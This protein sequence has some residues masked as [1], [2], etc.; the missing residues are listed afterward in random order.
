MIRK[1]YII[2]FLALP[3]G[4]ASQTTIALWEF[5][6]TDL[7]PF[8]TLSGDCEPNPM[9]PGTFGEENGAFVIR[10]IEGRICCPCGFMGGM[11]GCGF[12]DNIASSSLITIT[13]GAFCNITITADVRIE[14]GAQMECKLPDLPTISCDPDNDPGRDA[15]KIELLLDGQIILLGSYCGNTRRGDFT[16]SNIEAS[17]FQIIITGGTEADDEA[18]IIERIM[19]EGSDKSL[20]P[21]EIQTTKQ[22]YC[23]NEADVIRLVAIGGDAGSTYEWAFN[24]NPLNIPPTVNTYIAPPTL[25][26][27]GNYAV[28]ITETSG[29]T[30]DANVDITVTVCL[31]Q[32]ATFSMVPTRYCRDNDVLMLPDTSDEGVTGM[33]NVDQNLRLSDTVPFNQITFTP[34]PAFGIMPVDID[35]TIDTV[36]FMGNFPTDGVQICVYDELNQ[37]VNLVDLLQLEKPNIV[38]VRGFGRNFP[39][40]NDL[41]NLDV[42]TVNPGTYPFEFESIPAAE[43]KV[44]LI[45]LDI[46]VTRVGRGRDNNFTQCAMDMEPVDFDMLVSGPNI[47]SGR[48]IDIANTG[49]DLSQPDQVDV[50]ML[51]PGIYTF[52]YV[53]G[54]TPACMTINDTSTLTLEILPGSAI[55][56]GRFERTDLCEE[57]PFS[58]PVGGDIYDESNPSGT[59]VLFGE[60]ANGCDSTVIVNLVYQEPRFSFVPYFGCQGDGY[61]TIVNGTTYFEGNPFG[62]EMLTA[63]NGC[64]SIIT[65]D[66]IYNPLEEKQ[67]THDGCVGDGYSISINNIIYNEANPLGLDTIT[68]VNGCDTIVTIDLVFKPDTTG[69][70]TYFGN[71]GDVYNVTV[72][73]TL[74]DEFNP[75]GMEIFT[76]ANGCDS[77]VTID[78]VFVLGVIDSINTVHCSGDGYSVQAGNSTYDESNPSGVDSLKTTDNRD[79]VIITNLTFLLSGKNVIDLIKTSG[80]G[81][82]TTINSITYN[83]SNPTGFDTIILGAANGCDSLI[84]INIDYV[85]AAFTMIDSSFCIGDPFSITVGNSTYNQSNPAGRDTL[86]TV[87]GIDSIVSTNLVF[88]ESSASVFSDNRCSGDGFELTVG[89]ELFNEANPSGIVTLAGANKFGCDSLVQVLLIYTFDVLVDNDATICPDEEVS[90]GNSIYNADNRMGVDT[91]LG[92]GGCDTIITTTLTVDTINVDICTLPSCPNESNGTLKIYNLNPANTL[93]LSVNQDDFILEDSLIISNQESGSYVIEFVNSIGCMLSESIQIESL[94]NQ[95]PIINNTAFGLDSLQLGFSYGGAID[96]IEWTSNAGIICANCSSI[97]VDSRVANVYTLTIYD[98][99]GCTYLS[100]FEI[101]ENL[102]EEPIIFYMANAITDNGAPGNSRLFLQ[103]TDPNIISYDLAVYSRWGEIVYDLQNLSPND[104]STGWDGSVRGVIRQSNVFVYK[105]VI[106]KSDGTTQV[107]AGDVLLLK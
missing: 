60:A 28:T 58:F 20:T 85:E 92:S 3:Y 51:S 70:E 10:D 5:E 27:A 57:D 103:S 26:N 46:T 37:F 90:V 64:D 36:P 83:E 31:P 35:L 14:G 75:S 69:V 80:G 13:P 55:N 23:E 54:G 15:M 73:G 34:D 63:S 84:I 74:Y 66:L 77:V 2:L 32:T 48:Y 78:L 91:L 11:V 95:N 16:L 94:D 53:V 93:S 89:T 56:I 9:N 59:T 86:M 1:W 30:S 19:I 82:D 18:Y 62:E 49:L 98:Q 25:A 97:I 68:N 45:E 7:S 41:I 33:W 61:D 22:S 21:T 104:P 81:F 12:N 79:S 88:N 99:N 101:G 50:S 43:C 6:G 52:Q 105:L 76:A 107:E 47:P 71:S 87:L 65:I 40:V 96:S 72:N 4:L 67:E 17:F 44:T 39:D 102:T 29:C 24:G 38:N 100:S 106:R 8:E 42:S